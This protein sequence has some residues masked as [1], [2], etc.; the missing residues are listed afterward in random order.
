VPVVIGCGAGRRLRGLTRDEGGREQ[1]RVGRQRRLTGR[2]LVG[3]Q[4]VGDEIRYSSLVSE[5]GWLRGIRVLISLYNWLSVWSSH[6]LVKA[7]RPVRGLSAAVA[8][9]E[10][11]GVAA[12]HD[13]S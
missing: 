1:R 11:L 9:I 13:T 3:L 6:F 8:S 4:D 10:I 5:A 2:K 12:P 7:L